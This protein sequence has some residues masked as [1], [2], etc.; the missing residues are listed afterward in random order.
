MPNTFSLISNMQSESLFIEKENYQLH[1]KRFYTLENAPSVFLVHGSIEDGKIFYSKSGK[2]FAPFLAEN[3][4]DVFVADLR[5]RGKSKPHPSR[6]NNFGMESAFE[7][8][9]PDFIEKIKNITGKEPDHW[10]SH[11]WGGVHL[12]AYLAKNEAPNLKSMVFFGSKR[13]IRVRNLKKFLI[14]DLLWFGYCTFLAKTKGYL[15]ARKYKIGSADEAKDYFLEVNK[16]VR[17]RDW[18]DLRDDFD[19]AAALQSKTLPPILSI[20]GAND[21]QI[22][23]PI[24]C[25]RLLKELGDQDN[26]TFKVIGKKQGYKHDYDHINLLTHKDSKEDHFR[27]VLE[28]LRD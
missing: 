12:M 6:D 1:L 28:W 24:D 10:V 26:F 7:E 4:F 5:G 19:Y 2:G 15:P 16:W 25:R 20:T 9:I 21:K 14:V 13:D 8:D 3:G 23:H 18:K 11:S 22:G 17:S 27:E